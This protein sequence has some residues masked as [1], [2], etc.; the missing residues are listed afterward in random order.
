MLSKLLKTAASLVILPLITGCVSTHENAEVE[1]NH[2]EKGS[3]LVENRS[4]EQAIP[5]LNKALKAI[6]EP[7][8]EMKTNALMML[9]RT[10]DQ[11]SQPE[12]AILAA[13]QGLEAIFTP[14]QEIT[15]LS[16]LI[17]NQMKVDIEVSKSIETRRLQKFISVNPPH[18]LNDLGWSLD[19]K[20]DQYCLK[21]VH[22]LTFI[23]KQLASLVDDN[24]PELSPKVVSLIVDRYQFFN[25][26]LKSVPFE[27]HFKNELTVALLNGIRNLKT[28]E[29]AV[30]QSNK[31]L[32]FRN[33]ILRLENIEKDIESSLYK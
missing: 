19:F 22:Y 28:L 14:S 23:Q 26:Y 31:D 15:L 25:A 18:L 27:S 2:Y 24:H 5:T 21:E 29:I 9:V 4:F 30:P 13:E 32:V 20:C 7:K 12:K 1:A 11:V 6:P 3:A 33:L 10:Y 17:K 16:L 8:S